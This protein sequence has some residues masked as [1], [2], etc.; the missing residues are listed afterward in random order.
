MGQTRAQRLFFDVFQ[1]STA[2]YSGK[3]LTETLCCSE[4]TRSK[5]VNMKA[6]LAQIGIPY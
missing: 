5:L 1:Y 3:S 6:K 4:Q 2:L